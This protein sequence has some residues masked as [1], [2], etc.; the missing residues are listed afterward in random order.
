MEKGQSEKVDWVESVFDNSVTQSPTIWSSDFAFS[1]T[2]D[3]AITK[4]Y[5]NDQRI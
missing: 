3:F 2:R 1:E 4:L 5:S